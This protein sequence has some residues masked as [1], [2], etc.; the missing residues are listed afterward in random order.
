MSKDMEKFLMIVIGVLIAYV[1]Y[2]MLFKGSSFGA[3]TTV[4]PMLAI[5]KAIAQN[6]FAQKQSNEINQLTPL[7]NAAVT[8]AQ[9]ASSFV[10]NQIKAMSSAQ[11]QLSSALAANDSVGINKALAAARAAASNASIAATSAAAADSDITGYYNKANTIFSSS[12]PAS[13]F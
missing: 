6:S 9:Q 4:D 1:I 2:N 11:A 12:L 10:A 8:K 13:A 3:T 5:N 7:V